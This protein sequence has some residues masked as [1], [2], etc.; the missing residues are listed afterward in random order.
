[1]AKKQGFFNKLIMGADNAPDFT[2]SQ[3]PTTRWGLF[4]DLFKTRLYEI[5]KISLWGDVFLIPLLA[6]LILMF[7]NK[8]AYNIYIPF[9]GNLGI[10][11]PVEMNA[12]T[13][14]GAYAYRIET[15]KYA[16]LIPV[17]ALTFMLMSGIFYAM[18]RI[19]WG[20]D[21]S[22]TRHIFKGIKENWFQS[23]G[24]GLI[25]ALSLFIMMYS[26]LGNEL[27]QS[28]S[29]WNIAVTVLGVI[30]FVLICCAVVFM[31]TQM[32]TYKMK[33]LQLMTNGFLFSIALF[34]QT[35]F[36]IFLAG[37][38]LFV[39]EI[40]A[41][42]SPITRFTVSP[43]IY[44]AYLCLGVGYTS[45]VITV[46]SHYVFDKYLNDR[47]EGAKKNRGMYVRTPEEEKQAEINRIKNKNVV[48]GSA[49]VA[50]KLSS[51]DAGSTI[52]PLTA[53]YSRADLARLS[54]EKSK[55]KD[56]ADKE[57]EAATR[58]VEA[59]IQAYE[60]EQEKLNKKN[61][62]EKNKK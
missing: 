12:I 54:E 58:E 36:F 13:Q 23:L 9:D 15:M 18:R 3:L 52:T 47:V 27:R 19:A 42:F 29:F 4:R 25:F 7:L 11:Y 26:F 8:R 28:L 46:F 2:P 1:M 41:A 40:L 6:T 51:I 33:F 61:K 43:I 30:Q 10:G 5:F 57:R 53:S 48:Y 20:Q 35:V 60:R 44:I 59:E 62:K 16:V 56:E 49:Y 17:I 50:K 55:M 21:V 45:L 22:V 31:M 34:F 14:G 37:L 24:A 39:T 38:P 32:V